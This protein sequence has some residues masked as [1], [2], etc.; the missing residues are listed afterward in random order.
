[1]DYSTSIDALAFAGKLTVESSRLSRDNKDWA[2]LGIEGV[3]ALLKAMQPPRMPD[4]SVMG[5]NLEQIAHIKDAARYCGLKRVV[6]FPCNVNGQVHSFFRMY[7]GDVDAF[8][9]KL[10]IVKVHGSI[11]DGE[12]LQIGGLI[13]TYGI[14]V[15]ER[16]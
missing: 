15:Y 2:K 16:D 5:F 8:C 3:Q 14:I 4:I 11:S 1:M 12:E 10:G 6:L 7:E 13:K 9:T